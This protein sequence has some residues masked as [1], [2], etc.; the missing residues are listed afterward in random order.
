MVEVEARRLLASW[1]HGTKPTNWCRPT[2]SAEA[3]LAAVRAANALAEGGRD[4]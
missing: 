3:Y 1:R 2:K 4:S